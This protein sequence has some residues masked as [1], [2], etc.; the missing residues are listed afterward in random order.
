MII[1]FNK[2]LN[3]GRCMKIE[4]II[5]I[6]SLIISFALLLYNIISNKERYKL[7]KDI[8]DKIIC[9]HSKV[10][11]II[12]Y[13]RLKPNCNNK[14][15]YLSKLSMLIEEGRFYYPNIDKQDGK[16]KNKPSAY[17]G[18]RNV[19]LDILVILY[20]I[21]K[22]DEY[23]NDDEYV[24]YLQNQFSSYVISS[25]NVKSFKKEMTK[26]TKMLDKDYSYMD[27]INKNIEK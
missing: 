3:K 21:F 12:I 19:V 14:I 1:N 20:D 22:N 11:E 5:S 24:K 7:S 23:I 4:L 16:G 26:I 8:Y 13:L 18:Y 27:I 6:I 15:D 10:L 2:Y 9:W 17:K 25:V